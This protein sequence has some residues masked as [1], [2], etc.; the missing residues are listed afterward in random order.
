MYSFID[1]TI[2]SISVVMLYST[3]AIRVYRS[4]YHELPCISGVNVILDKA[5]LSPLGKH[6]MSNI[7]LYC[8]LFN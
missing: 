7:L 8:A 1:N 6:S 3:S 5:L 2:T 4:A